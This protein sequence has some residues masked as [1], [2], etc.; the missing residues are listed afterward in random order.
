MKLKTIRDVAITES[1]YDDYNF[2]E[3]LTPE[4]DNFAGEFNQDP[5]NKIVLWKV[6][7]YAAFDKETIELI[8]AIDPSSDKLDKS[9]SK[10]LLKKLLKTDGVGLP[11]AS[12]ILRFRNPKI[13]QIIDQRAYRFLCGN[14][15]KLPTGKSEKGI[16]EQIDKYLEYLQ[17]LKNTCQQ[18]SVPFEDAD[19]VL[20]IADKRVNG[21][22]KLKY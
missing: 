10:Q 20:Y 13:Y 15:M 4:L 21:H 5:L 22:I 2:Q 9:F 16:D 11:M 7:R 3:K 14:H 1:D 6:N 12:T 19:R 18:Y 17:E 8:N